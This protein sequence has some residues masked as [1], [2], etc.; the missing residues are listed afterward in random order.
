MTR[1]ESYRKLGD[2]VNAGNFQA[3]LE[4]VTPDVKFHAPGLGVDVVGH[5]ALR[6]QLIPALEA[7]EMSL[8][9]R[10]VVESGPFLVGILRQTGNVN[11]QRMSWDVCQ[12]LRWEGDKASEVWALRGSDPQPSP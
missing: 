9:V 10:D 7:A 5:D 4:F 2:Q 8:E 11:G 12:V 3:L 6:E 1:G